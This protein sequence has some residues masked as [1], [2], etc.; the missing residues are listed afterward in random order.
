MAL[1][2]DDDAGL[3]RRCLKGDADAVRTLVTRFQTDV[4]GLCLR[5]LHHRHDAED[6][7]QEVFLRVFR[8]LRRWDSSRPLRP[9][10]MGIAVNRCR[11]VLSQRIRRPELADYL[12]DVVP[13]R[14][15]DDSAELVREIEAAVAE[16]RPEY[17]SVFVLFHEQGQPYEDIAR[18]LKRPVGTVKT[19]LHRAR[20]EVLERLKRRGMV[21][22]VGHELP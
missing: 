20:L 5:M 11:T 10:V 18:S 13:G 1:V 16:L 6:V 17:R 14:P 8:S 22:E 21:P 2:A 4:Y 19:W 9:W 3:V 12:H 7:V 15:E